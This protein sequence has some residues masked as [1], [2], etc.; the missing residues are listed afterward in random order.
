MTLSAR[1]YGG[2][3]SGGC[4]VIYKAVFVFVTL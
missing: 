1:G 3:I 4:I 2:D